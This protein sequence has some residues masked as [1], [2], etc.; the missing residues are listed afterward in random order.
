MSFASS[1]PTDHPLPP[2]NGT[3]M[4]G[5][6]AVNVLPTSGLRQERRR[7]RL[8][9]IGMMLFLFLF[10]FA[11]YLGGVESTAFHQD[12]SRWLNRAHYL[13]DL[14]DPFG[15]TWNDQ[16]LTRGQPPVGS[17]MMGIGLLIQG[18]DLDTNPAYDFRRSKAF[19]EALGTIPNH[20]DL[21]AGRRWNSFLGALAVAAVY[22]IVR[23]LTNPVGG[24]VGSLFLIA[25]PLQSWHNRLALADTTLTITLALLL[26][27]VIQL[28]RRPSWGW[29]I[30]A[31]ILI[32]LGGANKFTPLALV[33]P[34]AGVG[35][36]MLIRGWLDN[37]KLRTTA[38]RGFLGLPTFRDPGWMLLS[39]PLTA[40][41]TFVL[42]YPYLWT[43]PVRRTLTLIR[44]RQDEMANQYR[45]YPQFRA[46]TPIDALGKT[47]NALGQEW[48]S[49]NEFLS[50]IGLHTIGDHLSLLDLVLASIGL[51]L[52][53]WIG[54]R[55]GIRSAELVVA[56]LILFQT[57]TII[58]NMRVDFERY[59][60]PI[61]LGEVVAIG[62][63][64][65][66][67]TGWLRKRSGRPAN[68]AD[69][70]HRASN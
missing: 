61:L 8:V 15:P 19:N 46:D 23:Q 22:L 39:T 42:I 55:K 44:F 35:A 47:I 2:P 36:V 4:T 57:A 13:T 9:D 62:C 65:G 17:Y 26:L 14:A 43:N 31:G 18:R 33:A 7:N 6:G 58:V 60:L 1:S 40:L 56:I 51:G 54:I 50:T 10:A 37:R 41:A 64:V 45:L 32:G 12:E 16:Y 29:A 30:A 52:M 5:N 66:Y 20:D 69:A 53:L 34:L 24:V 11:V 21:L 28:M 27:C 3:A 49:A 70:P 38:P 25:N 68:L 67:V 48:S 63:S 59:Y